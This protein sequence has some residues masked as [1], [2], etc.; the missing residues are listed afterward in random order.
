VRLC[1]SERCKVKPGLPRTRSDTIPLGYA[2]GYACDGPSRPT[3]LSPMELSSADVPAETP[4]SDIAVAVGDCLPAGL[5][6]Q[7]SQVQIL[8]PLPVRQQ[9]R[10]PFALR[11]GRV[12]FVRDRVVTADLASG[13]WR[14]SADTGGRRAEL[15][16]LDAKTA[17]VT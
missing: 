9:V 12:S 3:W 10:G 2:L 8:S 6:T 15:G 11:S 13:S 7:R 14:K 16:R 17:S 4:R 5:I 1:G